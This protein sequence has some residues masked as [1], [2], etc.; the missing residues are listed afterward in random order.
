MVSYSSQSATG[1][2]V[3]TLVVCSVSS[4]I[5]LRNCWYTDAPESNN[6]THSSYLDAPNDHQMQPQV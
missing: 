5:L 3:S 1:V 4:D 2:T 6:T